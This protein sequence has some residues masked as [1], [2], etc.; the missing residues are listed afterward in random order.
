MRKTKNNKRFLITGSNGLL[1]QK[2]IK[3]LINQKINFVATSKTNNKIVDLNF[4][5]EVL[6]ITNKAEINYILENHKPDVIIN[7]AAISNVDDCK[8]NYQECLNTNVKALEYLV[9]YCNANDCHLVHLSSDFVYSGNNYI[10]KEDDILSSAV[11]YYGNTKIEGE[12]LLSSRCKKYSIVRT[13]LVYGYNKNSARSNIVLWVKA[14]LEA[15]KK[16]NVTSNHYRT[17]TLAEDLAKACINLALKE[18]TGIYNISGKENISVY[19]FALKI[20]KIFNLNENLISP[21]HSS[22]INEYDKRPEKTSLDIYKAI[23]DINYNPKSLN[24]GLEIV[25]KQTEE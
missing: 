19:E 10:N 6:D 12:K 11:N 23:I 25:L 22:K 15:N 3:E 24:E 1:G 20:A 18:K 8:K 17:P 21:I 4:D 16:I 5:F 9:D 14:S 13:S 2:L 7:T